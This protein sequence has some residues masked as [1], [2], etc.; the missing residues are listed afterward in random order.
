MDT[1]K[2]IGIV[3]ILLMSCISFVV[4][5]STLYAGNLESDI[6]KSTNRVDIRFILDVSSDMK[7]NDPTRSRIREL[8][9]IV[10]SLPDNAVSGIWTYGKYVNMLVP[11]G[12]TT[13]DWKKQAV[14]KLD[15]VDGY[16]DFRN[17]TQA[18]EKASFGWQN[19]NG[20]NKYLVVLTS[21][22]LKIS[23][24]KVENARSQLDL[25]TKTLVKL[26]QGNIKVHT[27]SFG[28]QADDRLLKVLSSNTKGNWYKISSVENLPQVINHAY[29]VIATKNNLSM[30]VAKNIKNSSSELVNNHIQNHMSNNGN[31]PNNDDL[32]SAQHEKKLNL[33][34]KNQNEM[35]FNWPDVHS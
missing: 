2:K 9:K 10:K 6:S 4:G 34:Y 29:S 23:H 27:L 3:I 5:V 20:F 28:K 33:K 14:F 19:K 8:Q 22:D 13:N 7:K 17:L 12:A 31:K 25:L 1:N 35:E 26:K 24:S 21:G 18:I 30:Q 16:G 11:L 15:T 32:K